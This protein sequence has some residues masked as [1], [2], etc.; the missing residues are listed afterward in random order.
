ML[1]N[2]KFLLCLPSGRPGAMSLIPFLVTLFATAQAHL[3]IENETDS[4]LE[5]TNDLES[6]FCQFLAAKCSEYNL[7]VV[8]EEKAETGCGFQ[9]CAGPQKCCC[10]AD[11]MLILGENISASV[12]KGGGRQLSKT[13]VFSVIE[14]FK[15][16]T[17][18]IVSVSNSFDNFEIQWATNMDDRPDVIDEVAHYKKGDTEIVWKPVPATTVDN[19]KYYEISGQQ[20]EPSTTY[21]VRVR[22]FSSLSSKYSDSS[23]EFEF[24]TPASV[25]STILVLIIVLSCA[26][27][28][29]SSAIYG[30]YAKLKKDWDAT[31]LNPAVLKV[32]HMKEKMLEPEDLIPSII[33]PK[34]PEESHSCLVY[35]VALKAMDRYSIAVDSARARHF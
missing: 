21:M 9:R 20:L 14:S 23:E 22:R 29:T 7:V 11:T 24:T 17:P 13:T 12:W 19:L 2:K 16:R 5:C 10:S 27:A 26:A 1:E 32:K 15:P 25:S 28:I 4:D 35:G 33:S 34:T 6:V 30:C 18:T 8:D 3:G 31:F